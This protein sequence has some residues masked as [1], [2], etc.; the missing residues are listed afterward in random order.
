MFLS[1]HSYTKHICPR[2]SGQRNR[3]Q[4][5]RETAHTARAVELKAEET[6]PIQHNIHRNQESSATKLG[7]RV[8]GRQ[9]R[10]H[11][12]LH[13]S[14]TDR[15]RLDFNAGAGRSH[16]RLGCFPHAH[17][18]PNFSASPETPHSYCAISVPGFSTCLQMCFPQKL[19]LSP[20]PLLHSSKAHSPRFC[21]F[22]DASD[23]QTHIPSSAKSSNTTWVLPSG[24]FTDSSLTELT[25]SFPSSRLLHRHLPMSP[26]GSTAPSFPSHLGP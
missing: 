3:S 5:D 10:A 26:L 16:E 25:A 15:V 22:L 11:Q 1:K 12:G 20:L 19:R 7:R 18:T 2:C 24:W 23:S 13:C 6:S 9:S 14:S 17:P 21:G 8:P 4:H